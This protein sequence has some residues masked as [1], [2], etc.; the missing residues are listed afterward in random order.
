MDQIKIERKYSFTLKKDTEPW[1]WP[2]PVKKG[3][4]QSW[5]A[6]IVG[7]SL[8][9]VASKELS[10]WKLLYSDIFTLL[11]ND[12]LVRYNVWLYI[13]FLCERYNVSSIDERSAWVVANF[14][15]EYDL[16]VFKWSKNR[17]CSSFQI[18][19]LKLQFDK[20]FGIRSIKIRHQKSQKF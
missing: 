1:K 12:L 11:L 17:K 13:C 18:R 6:D 2:Y 4:L 9:L 8:K 7:N 20:V 16:R 19:S 10:Q 3:W 15:K 14:K 5:E